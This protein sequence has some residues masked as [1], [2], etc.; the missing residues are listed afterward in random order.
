MPGGPADRAPTGRG[1]GAPRNRRRKCGRYGSNMHTSRT[2]VATTAAVGLL[3][4]VAAIPG[5]AVAAASSAPRCHTRDVVAIVTQADRGAGNA[6]AYVV[7]VNA[8]P[9][10]C[11]V[12]GYPGLQLATGAGKPLAVQRT[13]WR[14]PRH[15]VLLQP[16]E[17]AK[18]RL[19]WGD[20]PTG[21]AGSCGPTAVKLKITPPDET[22]SIVLP[23]L[24]G[25]ACNGRLDV[26]AFRPGSVV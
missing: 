19:H 12:Y 25:A 8:T 6:Y 18:A 20:V 4:T 16:G 7:L 17:S 23:W 21:A 24:G 22:A 26:R 5:T 9:A 11:T 1:H 10:P 15:V 2:I 3:A 14:G 13:A